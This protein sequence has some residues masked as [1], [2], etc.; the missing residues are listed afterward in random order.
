MVKYKEDEF[1]DDKISFENI[2]A[3]L[4]RLIIYHKNVIYI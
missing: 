2:C 3:Y 1:K 4:I